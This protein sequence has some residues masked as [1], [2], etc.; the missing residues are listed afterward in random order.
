MQTH[1]VGLLGGEQMPWQSTSVRHSKSLLLEQTPFTCPCWITQNPRQVDGAFGSHCSP[2]S[3]RPLPQLWRRLSASLTPKTVAR[4]TSESEVNRSV[5][6]GAY[7]SRRQL[8]SCGLTNGIICTKVTLGRPAPDWLKVLLI[9][10]TIAPMKSVSL[11]SCRQ[12]IGKPLR[13]GTNW[14]KRRAPRIL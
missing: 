13:A 12:A 10:L 2:S 3:T 6:S 8:I 4:M 7:W 1:S 9:G 14:R 5:E 11:R